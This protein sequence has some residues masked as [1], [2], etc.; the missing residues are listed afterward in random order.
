MPQS[1]LCDS[2]WLPQVKVAE[3]EIQHIL[4]VRGHA[5]GVMNRSL[6]YGLSACFVQSRQGHVTIIQCQDRQVNVVLLGLRPLLMNLILAV[7]SGAP[8]L[9]GYVAG[10]HEGDDVFPGGV[11]GCG[12][13][14]AA[15]HPAP[16]RALHRL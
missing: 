6:F 10:V 4:G 12:A 3:A 13:A 2:K 11:L 9:A 5:C 14:A 1:T 15:A 8:H 16:Q 7:S